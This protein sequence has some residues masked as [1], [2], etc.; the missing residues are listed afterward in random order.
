MI[1]GAVARATAATAVHPLNV[2]KT[3]LQLG[4]EMPEWRWHTLSRGGGSQFIMSVPH[5]AMVRN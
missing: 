1:A 5:G 3:M 4:R 2:I